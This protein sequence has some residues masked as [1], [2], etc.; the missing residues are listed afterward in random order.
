MRGR[1]A[2]RALG[3]RLQIAQDHGHDLRRRVP[4]PAHAHAG[5]AVLGGDDLVRHVLA[6]AAHLRVV[7]LAAHQALDGADGAAR[8]GAHLLGGGRPHQDLVRRLAAERHHGRRRSPALGVRYHHG[9][10]PVDHRH[11]RLR[12]PEIDPQHPPQNAT[13]A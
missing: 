1:L 9:R 3:L 2:Q 6:V 4:T 8:V 7:D 5:V 11:P 12:G 13:Q 10:A